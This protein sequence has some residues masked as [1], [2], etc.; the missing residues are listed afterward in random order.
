MSYFTIFYPLQVHLNLLNSIKTKN[1]HR[2]DW[3]K[4]NNDNISQ[5]MSFLLLSLFIS[6]VK[7]MIKYIILL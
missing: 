3:E 7:M 1:A 2:C 6:I 5:I 4:K